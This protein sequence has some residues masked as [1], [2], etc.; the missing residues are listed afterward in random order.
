MSTCVYVPRSAGC[1]AVAWVR[2]SRSYAMTGRWENAEGRMMNERSR[3]AFAVL[4]L[5]ALHILSV[6][7]ISQS[8]LR[9]RKRADGRNVY[10]T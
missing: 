4:G 7:F 2:G 10:S 5:P 9:V 6:Y 1:F 3:R 8:P